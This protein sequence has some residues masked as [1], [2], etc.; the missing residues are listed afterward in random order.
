MRTFSHMKKIISVITSNKEC[1]QHLNRAQTLTIVSTVIQ[2]TQKLRDMATYL[3]FCLWIG[4]F[5]EIIISVV[6]YPLFC[7]VEGKDTSHPPSLIL[8]KYDVTTR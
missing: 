8:K 7:L 4:N 6:K 3:Y 5:E 2:E 1:T